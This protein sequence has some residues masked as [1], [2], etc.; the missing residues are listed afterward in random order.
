M[1]KAEIPK[2]TGISN[3]RFC[4]SK[5]TGK[6]IAVIPRIPNMLNMLEPTT[7]PIAT[8]AFPSRAPM[9]LTVSSGVDVPTPIIAAPMT[10]S[11][12][13]YLLAM[14]TDPATRKSA[15]N[16]MPASEIKRMIYSMV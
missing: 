10:K 8:S 3:L 14:D 12:T 5:L 4:L 13:L 11:E 1:S 6:N 7:L 9:K 16:T 2:Q 15:P